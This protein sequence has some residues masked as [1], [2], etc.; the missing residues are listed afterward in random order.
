MP[1]YPIT[2]DRY[3]NGSLCFGPVGRL[4]PPPGGSSSPHTSSD[5]PS[6]SQY[7][8]EGDPNYQAPYFPILGWE[9]HAQ[10]PILS[11]NPEH[12]WESAYVY[13]PAAIVVDDTVWLLYRAQNNT[14]TSSIGLA[15]SKN[16]IDFARYEKPVLE[17][18]E[19]YETPGGC[20]DPRITRV[21]GTFYMTY[22]G[23]ESGLTAHLCL[24]T[25]TD[26]VHWEKHGPVFTKKPKRGGIFSHPWDKSGAIFNEPNSDGSYRMVY[27]APFLSQA[28][29]TDLIHWTYAQDD[30]S[31][32]P[33]LFH[34][35]DLLMEPGPSPIKTRDGKWLIVY[36]GMASGVGGYRTG[37][38]STGQM[39][40]D[41]VAFPHGPPVARVETPLLQPSTPEEAN[42]QVNNVIFSE[43]MVQYHGKWF[44]Y[45]GQSDSF[46]G[47]ATAP[48]QS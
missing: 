22:V 5:V 44:L 1:G 42:G 27:G 20:E 28:T 24:A 34:W 26:L 19:A 14:K 46:I 37:Q 6:I 45:Y 12:N 31:W 41:P 15:W 8:S 47:V 17:P 21:N 36:N 32:A 16:G 23:F 10:N 48:V 35:E 13:N 11:P 3:T 4:W 33:K 29:S 9:K 2:P 43:G 25:S 39:L 7:S 18:T 40:V 30:E 38:Y